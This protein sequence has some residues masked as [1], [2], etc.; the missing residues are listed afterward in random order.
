MALALSAGMFVVFVHSGGSS[1]EYR[2]LILLQIMWI[3]DEG[4]CLLGWFLGLFLGLFLVCLAICVLVS[5]CFRLIEFTGDSY[6]TSRKTARSPSEKPMTT[7][8]HPF[9]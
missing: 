8:N 5:R 7:N 6:G 2:C 9:H 1:D 4:A 3:L